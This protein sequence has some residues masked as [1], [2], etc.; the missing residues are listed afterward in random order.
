[1][2]LGVFGHVSLASVSEVLP[3]ILLRSAYRLCWKSILEES[4]ESG[5]WS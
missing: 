3:Y 1:M 5:W 4:W 2:T